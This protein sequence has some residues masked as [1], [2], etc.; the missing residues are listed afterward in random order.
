[1][2]ACIKFPYSKFEAFGTQ[3]QYLCPKNSFRFKETQSLDE[4]LLGEYCEDIDEWAQG[5]CRGNHKLYVNTVGS[6]EC[7][8]SEGYKMNRTGDCVTL[9]THV[10]CGHGICK[11]SGNNGF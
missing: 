11:E 9:C 10:N 7:N 1:M 2:N 4:M 5:R 3:Y 6:Y 8:C